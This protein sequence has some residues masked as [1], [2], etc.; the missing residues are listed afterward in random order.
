[1]KQDLNLHVNSK[2]IFLAL[3]FFIEII[4]G[5]FSSISPKYSALAV[6]ALIII[7]AVVI[8]LEPKATLALIFFIHPLS[9]FGVNIGVAINIHLIHIFVPCLI[10]GLFLRAVV[11]KEIDFQRSPLDIP[12]IMFLILATI[13]IAW[14]PE[15]T[16]YFVSLIQLIFAICL[17]FLVVNLIRSRDALYMCLWAFFIVIVILIGFEFVQVLGWKSIGSYMEMGYYSR[18]GSLSNSAASLAVD[19][20]VGFWLTLALAVLE[21]TRFK[22]NLLYFG[23]SFMIVA[24]F[25]T[26]I[27]AGYV[28]FGVSSVT[29][30]LSKFQ[31]SKLLPYMII[32]GL[33]IAFSTIIPFSKSPIQSTI[34]AAFDPKDLSMVFRYLIW[35]TSYYMIKDNLFFGVGMGGFPSSFSKYNT[36]PLT[37]KHIFE[38][39]LARTHNLYLDFLT[40]LGIVGFLLFLVIVGL[41]MKKL[42]LTFSQV[43]GTPDGKLIICMIMLIISLLIH[44]MAGSEK[45]EYVLW[46]IFGLT[47]AVCSITEKDYQKDGKTTVI[48]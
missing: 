34:W 11:K 5:T 7:V 6:G 15:I 32:G 43:K 35:G 27:K 41:A 8:V 18:L 24:L 19:I 14:S 29:Y 17:Y 20:V 26:K 46:M 3:L 40:E 25:F 47:M 44:G 21:K 48:S 23:S 42:I 9:L 37:T 2:V 39:G 12:I 10:I 16:E 45:N 38:G 30:L 4:I 36:T 31:V 13:S 22:R 1:M 28:A 33:L